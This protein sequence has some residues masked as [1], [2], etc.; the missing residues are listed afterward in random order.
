MNRR[1]TA[2]R[3]S[4]LKRIVAWRVV[5]IALL[6]VLGLGEVNGASIAG[7]REVE[8]IRDRWGTPHVFADTDTG[9]MYGLGYAAADD[10]G[11]QMHYFLRII[12]GQEPVFVKTFLA[13]AAK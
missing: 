5:S 4:L 6:L 13:N 12:Q 9:A 11:F 7:Q 2:R 10:R 8:L 1:R 3:W